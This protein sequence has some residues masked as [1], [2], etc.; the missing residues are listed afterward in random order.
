MKTPRL[1]IFL[2]ND[3]LCIAKVDDEKAGTRLIVDIEMEEL[4]SLSPTDVTY[5]VG[6]T[7]LNIL[8]LWHPQ[9]FGDWQV[10]AVFTPPPK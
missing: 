2:E 4:K 9:E 8:R 10:P 5:R 1:E 3:A 6:G 7:V